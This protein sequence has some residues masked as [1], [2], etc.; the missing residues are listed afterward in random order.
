MFSDVGES[1]ELARPISYLGSDYGRWVELV[2]Q[3][4]VELPSLL[5][6]DAYSYTFWMSGARGLGKLREVRRFK[7]SFVC[8]CI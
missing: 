1:V 4:I 7:P 3:F 2:Y 6:L 5:G 8:H